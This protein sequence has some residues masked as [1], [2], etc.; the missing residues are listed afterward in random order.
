MSYKV[1][2]FAF[3]IVMGLA[4][5]E[6]KVDISNTL[7]AGKPALAVDAFITNLPEKQ[8]IYLSSTQYYFDNSGPK[9]ISGAAVKVVDESTQEEFVFEESSPGQYISPVNGDSMLIVGHPYRLNIEYQG[10]NYTAYSLMTRVPPIDSILFEPLKDI[11]NDIIPGKYF[12]EFQAKDYPGKGDHVWIRNYKNG[13][14]ITDADRIGIAY[15]GTLFDTPDDDGALFVYPLRIFPV[16]DGGPDEDDQWL[17]G[18][19]FGVELFSITPETAAFLQAVVT[20]ST[21]GSNGPLGALFS[22]PPANVPTNIV[23]TTSKDNAAVGFFCTSAVS[24]A[25]TIVPNPYGRL[26]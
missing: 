14:R 17:D 12:A 10:Q 18:Q 4:A 3:T 7:K 9:R 24:R 2:L 11:N 16:N 21:Q 20:Q 25:E 8:S 1:I 23:N 6:D 26:Q 22:P 13:E 19:L 15:D 5:C